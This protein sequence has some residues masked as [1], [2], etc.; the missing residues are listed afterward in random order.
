MNTSD[1]TFWILIIS[2]AALA[3][4]LEHRLTKVETMIDT[5]RQY[6]G[7]NGKIK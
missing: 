6:I 4:R 7:M 5:I 1:P 3:V 2:I